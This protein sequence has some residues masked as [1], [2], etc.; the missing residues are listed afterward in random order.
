MCVTIARSPERRRNRSRT[1]SSWAAVIG[2]LLGCAA[3]AG[4]DVLHLRNGGTVEGRVLSREEGRYEVRTLVGI[5]RVPAEVVE[6]VENAETPFDEY[7]RRVAELPDTAADHV[8]LAAWC[9]ERGLRAE[10]IAHLRRAIELD[11]QHAE[12]RQA[13]GYVRVG[14]LWVDGRRV[15]QRPATTPAAEEGAED[16][17]RLA[18]AIQTQWYR[19]I[20]AIRASLL[21]SS[22]GHLVEQGRALI[23]EIRDPLAILPLV[24]VLSSGGAHC[25][26]L[27]VEVLREFP[28]DEATMN[29]GVLGLVDAHPVVREGA[30]AELARRNDPRIV[31]QYRQALRDGNDALVVRAAYGLG[32]LKAMEAVPDL[33]DVLT[34]AR[35]RW[36]EVRVDRYFR[37]WPRVFN[38]RTEILLGHDPCGRAVH[39]PEI[40]VSSYIDNIRNEWRYLP[41]TV[42]RTEV[43]EALKE[44]T[45]QNF[46]FEH[47][48]WRR[49]YE[50][51]RP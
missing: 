17:E 34:A 23:L 42:Y 37:G 39:R 20:A 28:Q 32:R 43:L 36:V 44:I 51:Q 10:R 27:L 16:P 13:L 46:G 38:R 4:A 6:R 41:V 33:V 45:G 5:V 40:G 50:E 19:R 14:A 49:W 21:E 29:L 31:A 25:R 18:A 30:V 22:L 24:Q 2:A 7:D 12:A 8:A 15:I 35:R 26:A 9:Q 48:A 47:A 3:G 1:R 11:P